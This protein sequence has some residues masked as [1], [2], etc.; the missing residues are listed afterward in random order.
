MLLGRARLPGD[1]LPRIVTVRDG[2]ATDITAKAVPTAR[3]VCETEDPGAY[4]AG[5]LGPVI[6]PVEA[7][8]ENSNAAGTIPASRRCSRRSTCRR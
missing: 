8:I 1:S 2:D 7:L 5:A 4:V 3:D 6:G